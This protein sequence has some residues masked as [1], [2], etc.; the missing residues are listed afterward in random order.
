[1]VER[2]SAL[3]RAPARPELEALI[4]NAKTRVLCTATRRMARALL[5]SLLLHRSTGFGSP[6]YLR[7]GSSCSSWR[8]RTPTY[9]IVSRN[10]T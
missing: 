1:M 2:K 10:R 6:R 4:E 3:T 5:A 7:K 8:K 9:M